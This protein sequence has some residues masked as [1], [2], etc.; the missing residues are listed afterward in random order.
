MHLILH[1]VH[2][3]TVRATS[4]K[5][6]QQRLERVPERF[7]EVAVEVGVDERIKGRVE[8]PDP[9]QYRDDDVRAGAGLFA[10][11]RRDDHLSD[12]ILTSFHELGREDGQSY[13]VIERFTIKRL[14][15]EE[16]CWS[17]S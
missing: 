16:G 2:A 5:A 7:P 17:A 10:A 15:E 4:D 11:Q 14:E 13:A 1:V 12:N 6:R 3:V 9:E 8:V